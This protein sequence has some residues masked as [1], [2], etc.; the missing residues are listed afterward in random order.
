MA[1]NRVLTLMNVLQRLK[2][3]DRDRVSL[4]VG[5]APPPPVAPASSEAERPLGRRRSE[6]D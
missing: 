6:A 2:E 3:R 4:A 1:E 5:D